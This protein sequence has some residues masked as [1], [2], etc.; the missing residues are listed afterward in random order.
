[1]SRRAT[2]SYDDWLRL[3]EPEGPFFTAVVLRQAFPSGLDRLHASTRVDLKA[4]WEKAKEE[5]IDRTDWVHWL[6]R[7][8]LEWNDRLVT[9]A[10]IPPTLV[11]D[12]AEHDIVLRPD[13]VLVAKRPGTGE[14]VP[15][16]LVQIVPVGTHPNRRI[17]G[18]PWTATPVQRAA[19]L[20]RSV[21]CPLAIITDGDLITVVR[22]PRDEAT[23]FGTWR[24]SLFIS[25]ADTLNAF[26]SLFNLRRFQSLGV[27]DTPERLLARSATNQSE[28]TDTLG[29]QAREAVELLVNAISRGSLE[30]HGRLLADVT[31]HDV[32]EAAVTVLMRIVILLTSEERG[33]LPADDPFYGST[34]A[35]S[36][37]HAQLEDEASV[38]QEQLELRH[39][40]WHRLLATSRAVH[41]G[42]R[43]HQLHVPAYGSRLFDPERFPFL[44][45]RRA[46]EFTGEPLP[47]DD[48]SM[49][50]ILRSLVELRL[51]G[52]LRRLSY[53]HLEVEQV[54]HVYESLLDHNAVRADEIVL[55]LIG[56]AGEEP[57]TPLAD[58]E[59]AAIDGQ[60][61]LISL[62][63][64]ATGRTDKA[65]TKLLND[66]VIETRRRG[67]LEAT[68]NDIELVQR[69]LPYANLLRLDLRGIPLVF[70]PGSV[71]V[72]E[73]TRKRDSGTAYTTRELADEV[74]QYALEP[75]VYS[76]GPLEDLDRKTWRLKPSSEIL[77][78]KICDPA[79]G[80]GAIAVAACR[81]L[82]ERLVEAWRNEGKVDD[83]AAMGVTSDDPEHLDVLVDARRRVA[84]RCIYGVDRD[85]MAVEMAKLSLWLVTLAKDRPFTFLD[86]AIVA[87]DS[88]LGITDS[89][90]LTTFHIDPQRG[91]A[92]HNRFDASALTIENALADVI[93]RRQ[94]LEQQPV[95]TIVDVRL[96]TEELAGIDER[97]ADLKLVADL[98]IGAALAVGTGNELDQRLGASLGDVS[99]LLSAPSDALRSKLT[100]RAQSWLDLDLP[101]GQ[102]G[103]RPMHWAITFPEVMQQ[104]GFHG[105]VGNPPF[106]GGQRITGAMGT[107]FR[108]H[109][110]RVVAGDRRGSADLVAYFF[111]RAA[112]LTRGSGS[113]GFLATNTIAQGDT[114]EVGLDH[115]TASGWSIHRAVKTM[116]WPGVAT[117]EVAQVWMT[118]TPGTSHVLDG[119][120]VT[121]I[122]SAL[123]RT[124]RASGNPY[125]LSAN[126]GKSFIG[127][128]VLGLG[129]TM[130]PDEAAQLIR[131]DPRNGEVIFPYLNGDDLNSSPSQSPSRWVINFFDW[132]EDRAKSYP[133]CYQRIYE[134]VRPDRLQLNDSNAAGRR[135]KEYWWQYASDAKALY[136]ALD[137]SATALVLTRVSKT[138]QPCLVE[139]PMV[140]S[141]ALVVFADANLFGL[142]SSSFHYHWTIRYASGLRNDPR[143]T[144]SDVFETLALPVD[145][146][147]ILEAGAKL[148]E[149]RRELMLST[150]LGVTKTYNRVHGRDA[151]SEIG[152]LRDLHVDLDHAVAN[153]Y[154]WDDLSLNHGFHPTPQGERFTIS[155]AAQVEVLDRLL[156]LN[157]QRHT[158]E[159]VANAP[160]STGKTPA[161]VK[162]RKAS[163]ARSLFGEEG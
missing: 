157:H 55:G 91:N 88:L 27:D 21:D 81:F 85:P 56:K 90:Q 132:S 95:Q 37:L 14:A 43:H 76:P 114:R 101:E 68:N 93:E 83:M 162:G 35:M 30:Q 140:L 44:E 154:G 34:Y 77:D 22:A 122:T 99:Q 161:K 41:A 8:A 58:L 102:P 89:R 7:T 84:E 1:M 87:G 109:L 13:A 96:K 5:T 71:Y 54:G 48:L 9:G 121:G 127:S 108:N 65:V 59:T 156:E 100:Q 46:G 62:L 119:Q 155:P 53:K 50:G 49:L 104:G 103:R 12:A 112:L 128:Y 16:V 10:E 106:L 115:L 28:I 159:L 45:G 141:D 120:R 158:E 60:P 123:T 6:L 133:D 20:C 97:L 26:V 17:P 111:L 147:V 29:R 150:G 23:G 135:R 143:Y 117:L 36:T 74:A 152:H 3:L 149:Y 113:I 163:F 139:L 18:D 107:A 15:R 116:P 80:S 61:A 31:P 136:R 145:P 98:V 51:P 137:G 110:I 42:I 64:E 125:R 72:T 160:G 151:S 52:E 129:F 73:T 144:P 153:A 131:K 130:T 39:T 86:H 2:D 19:L 67:L 70:L 82:A 105:F 11:H 40:A 63:R 146:S 57:E 78:L 4:Q 126:A 124:G 92:L 66:E 25:E 32:Y 134:R 138:L 38:M 24:A 94:R 47:V 75:L 148:D 33:L 142:L 69:L 118:R 79:I